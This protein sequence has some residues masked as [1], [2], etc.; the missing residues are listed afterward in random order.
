MGKYFG[1][2]GFRGE[3]NEVLTSAKAFRIGRYLGWYYGQKHEDGRARIIIGKDTRRSSYTLEYALSSGITSSGSDAYLLHV[4][5][6]PSVSYCCR[7]DG[8]DCGVMISA[9]H[10]PY[11]DNGIK[12]MRA[13]GQKIEAE[14]EE[15]IE[16]YIDGEIE[17]LPLAKREKMG[18][19]V[20]YA[21]GRNRYIG[22]LMSIPTRGF[23]GMS[24]GLDCANGAS[25]NI[26]RAVYEA[27]GAK[28]YVINNTP[29]GVNINE[30]CGSTHM[31]SL[32]KFVLENHLNVGFAYDG[33]ADRCLCIDEHGN[34]TL[35]ALT[36][37]KGWQVATLL[38]QQ[39]YTWEYEMDN[40]WTR[41]F[42]GA[43]F[44]AIKETGAYTLD[45]YNEMN[46]KGGCIAAYAYSVV[47]GYPDAKAALSGNAKCVIEQSWFDEDGSGIA[48]VYGPSMKEYF[49]VITPYTESTA[50]FTIFSKEAV[51]SGMADEILQMETGGSF[52]ALWDKIVNGA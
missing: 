7:T 36:E 13:N 47:A 32:K 39:Q 18:N 10:N 16:A 6:T 41:E 11:Y 35:Y 20:D 46:E 52:D 14:I 12:I 26:A 25:W 4:S 30:N 3:A 31:E 28:V 38:D 44:R 42:D 21:A 48:I 33:D 50:L 51:G 29:N 15:K 8:F 43:A 22:Y 49:V 19:V 9:S 45:T 27:L 1:T 34:I 40:T 37:L 2:D 17:E 23:N 5:T 24:V